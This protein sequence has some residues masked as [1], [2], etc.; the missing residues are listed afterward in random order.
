MHVAVDKSVGVKVEEC[1]LVFFAKSRFV[2]AERV[3]RCRRK[4]AACDD[5]CLQCDGAGK[6]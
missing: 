4:L 6:Y 1:N 5:I 3:R 2:L